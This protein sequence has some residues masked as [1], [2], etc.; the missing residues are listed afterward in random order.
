[1]LCTRCV[2]Q[3]Q[4]APKLVFG[5]GTG[6][7]YD[8]LPDPSRMRGG[9]PSPLLSPSACASIIGASAPPLTVPPLLFL[10][11][12]HCQDGGEKSIGRRAD[13]AVWRTE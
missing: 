1:M 11:I 4:N 9:Y 3:A 7:A 13:C 10:Q 8:A 5:R 12:K 6:A 2:S